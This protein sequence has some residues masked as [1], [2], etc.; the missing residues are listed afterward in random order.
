MAAQAKLQIWE[1]SFTATH[2]E[3]LLAAP[4]D[5]RVKLH[6]MKRT[7]CSAAALSEDLKTFG[8]LAPEQRGRRVGCGVQ[9]AAG[10]QQ[11][12]VQIPTVMVEKKCK[13]LI[14]FS[15]LMF[16]QPSARPQPC[17]LI[18]ALQ[19]KMGREGRGRGDGLTSAFP[20]L[21]WSTLC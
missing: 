11:I 4:Q 17:C 12:L 15:C 10:S 21:C 3:L 16:S 2:P 13:N 7:S 20:G 9:R 8:F 19:S 18:A 5:E 14:N 6:K 1:I